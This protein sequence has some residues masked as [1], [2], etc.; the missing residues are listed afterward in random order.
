[1][2]TPSQPPIMPPRT[3]RQ[4]Q[5]RTDIG[6]KELSRYFHLSL[7]QAAEVFGVC[8]TTM[9]KIC[10]NCGIQRWPHRKHQALK[11]HIARLSEDEAI[12]NGTVVG[13][14][15]ATPSRNSS[16]SITCTTGDT[17]NTNHVGSLDRFDD[18][19][20]MCH[21]HVSA[22]TAMVLAGGVPAHDRLDLDTPP[23][24]L[25]LSGAPR[26]S[27]LLSM[28]RRPGGTSTPPHSNVALTR[29][30]NDGFA[31]H[32]PT[33]SQQAQSQTTNDA[34]LQSTLQDDR[35]PIQGD[36]GCSSIASLI[37]DPTS[38]TPFYQFLPHTSVLPGGDHSAW[39]SSSGAQQQQQQEYL[40]WQH[41]HD[42]WRQ[43]QEDQR[44][45]MK[46]S[47]LVVIMNQEKQHVEQEQQHQQQLQQ[48][49]RKQWEQQQQLC[50]AQIAEQQQRLQPLQE[51]RAP[52]PQMSTIPTAG[53]TQ[54]QFLASSRQQQDWTARTHPQ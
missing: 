43:R 37:Q 28:G 10:R 17:I 7:Q 30:S 3:R 27:L 13:D 18:L 29:S 16:S 12:M 15:T 50:Q 32:L 45:Q 23:N 53:A 4:R 8:P 48:L 21:V 38:S 26:Q 14:N 34:N 44:E 11:R 1:M 39:T 31:Q 24:G 33:Q 54:P 5:D 46:R 52:M 40:S 22:V 42:T 47:Q 6:K 36:G 41:Q 2:A 25:D 35:S 49:L 20:P 9:K 19:P 51:Y